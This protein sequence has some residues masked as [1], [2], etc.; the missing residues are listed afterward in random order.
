MSME[1][2]IKA[3]ETASKAASTAAVSSIGNPTT[4]V[5]DPSTRAMIRSPCSCAA[6]PP[7]LSSG[8]IKV[9]YSSTSASLSALNVTRVSTV[10]TSSKPFA[11]H[12]TATAVTTSCV[13]P[14]NIPIIRRASAMS[15]GF[16]SATPPIAT[17]VSAAST[18]ASA[19]LPATTRA[20]STALCRVSASS[21]IA[22]SCNS[23][24]SAGAVSNT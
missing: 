7:A 18:T 3:A 10:N 1:G 15:T 23:S 8:L 24:M 17:S 16:V 20:F 4:F 11:A 14:A 12:T 13:L 5:H 21:A 22:S 6:Y 9:R 19:R 2:A